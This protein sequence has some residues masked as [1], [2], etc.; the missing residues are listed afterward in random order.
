MRR[1]G[2]LYPLG[3]DDSHSQKD[4]GGAWIMVGAEKL[5]YGAVIAALEKGDFYA[6]TGPE[7]HEVSIEDGILTVR[8]SDAQRIVVDSGTRFAKTIYPKAPDKLVRSGSFNLKAWLDACT[9]ESRLDWIRVSVVDAYG[10]F[11]STRAFYPDEL[12]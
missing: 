7:L 3:A 5:E 4:L 12:K 8:C 9:G 1:G 10:N 2:N 6:S 11:A